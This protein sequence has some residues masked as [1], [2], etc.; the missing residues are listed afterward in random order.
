MNCREVQENLSLYLDQEMSEA[1][2]STVKNHLDNCLAC[3]EELASLRET[4]S[5][6][7]SLE[8]VIPPAS[9]R[10]ELYAKLENC[11]SQQRVES[12]QQKKGVF[13]HGLL[14]KFSLLRRHTVFWPVAITVI[15]LLI[16]S[17]ALLDGVRMAGSKSD[18]SLIA[19]DYDAGQGI[20]S[21]GLKSGESFDIAANQKMENMSRS[22]APKMA[23]D[24]FADRNVSAT[25]APELMMATEEAAKQ[26]AAPQD[27][28]A[29]KTIERKLIKN[30]EIY[31]QVDDYDTAI[32]SLKE[33]VVSLEG[34]ITN[35]TANAVDSKGTKRGS[36]QIRIPQYSFEDFLIGIKNFGKLKNSHIYSQ[37]VTEEY[38]DVESRLKT[39]RTKEERLL[40]ILTQSGNLSDIL[41][42]ENELAN[43]R[44]QLESLEGRMRYL[45]NQT[46]YST[47]NISVEQ[48]VVSTQQVTTSG[49]QGVVERAKEA[50]IKA[51]NNIFLGLGMSIVF[52]SAA[53][54]YLVVAGIFAV[55][56]WGIW[57]GLKLQKKE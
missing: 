19:E 16:V 47:V 8:E 37:D 57:R 28:M 34:Y 32:N 4:V 39:M 44:A 7:S 48:L 24:G 50:F 31:L 3:R 36:L 46:E 23:A 49:L 5:L 11:V 1:E 51:I 35:E 10:S 26:L 22:I 29:D 56:V 12:G 6:L 43:T 25:S 9:F 38:I 21:Y 42:V 18:N 13:W 52:I 45:N 15:L 54:P 30:A 14:E 27:E 33:Q 17:P 41:A 40:N 2:M 20:M 53:I 55:A